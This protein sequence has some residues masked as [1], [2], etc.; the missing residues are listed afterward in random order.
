MADAK[1][2]AA[3]AKADKE[4]LE[5]WK[6][7]RKKEEAWNDKTSGRILYNPGPMIVEDVRLTK[8]GTESVTVTS[9]VTGVTES[10]LFRPD[11]PRKGEAP[12]SMQNYMKHT[13]D[14]QGNDIYEPSGREVQK[15]IEV[16]PYTYG[17]NSPKAGQTVMSPTFYNGEKS[18]VDIPTSVPASETSPAMVGVRA[19]GFLKMIDDTGD[20]VRL[21]IG[22]RDQNGN[23]PGY[24][25]GTV[26]FDMPKAK[27]AE[28]FKVRAVMNELR[29][30]NNKD[31]EKPK[32]V[33]VELQGRMNAAALERPQ[34]VQRENE[35]AED[36]EKRQARWAQSHEN[37]EKY[38]IQSRENFAIS[39]V[40]DITPMGAAKQRIY[41]AQNDREPREPKDDNKATHRQ[42]GPRQ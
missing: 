23:V 22:M 16:R 21:M 17:D 2:I 42:S 33:Y 1:K 40:L 30:M 8:N 15:I 9:K 13:Q 7:D 28:D 36:F 34:P 18:G 19:E 14:E 27:E 4:S 39:E 5:Q 35:S 6:R 24:G 29:G 3:K 41:D 31:G 20:S 10:V 25:A 38:G 11:K 32:G 37:R 12:A 26:F